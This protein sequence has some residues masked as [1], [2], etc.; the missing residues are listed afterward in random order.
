MNKA[1]TQFEQFDFLLFVCSSS[2]WVDVVV[3]IE[4][5]RWRKKKRQTHTESKIIGNGY[6][7]KHCG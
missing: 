4:K 6:E 5:E 3:Q 2:K 1:H 7:L